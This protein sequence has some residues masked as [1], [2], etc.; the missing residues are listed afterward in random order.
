MKRQKYVRGGVEL[1]ELKETIARLEKYINPPLSSL[2]IDID[3]Y[4]RKLLM[5]SNI[6]SFRLSNKIVGMGAFYAN[7]KVCR[8]G[9][10]SFIAVD[11]ELQG[12]GIGHKIL[13][14]CEMIASQLGMNVMR[15]EVFGTNDSAI[16]FYKRCG[17]AE[18]LSRNDSI[19][20]FKVI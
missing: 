3:T 13:D 6:V 1:S 14:Q 15:L 17:Y 4:S 20:M 19:F 16:G 10:L 5:H 2:N 11:I 9:Y 8:E 7:D 18:Y 12:K